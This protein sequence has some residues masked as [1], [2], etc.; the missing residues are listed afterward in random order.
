M[1]PRKSSCDGIIVLVICPFAVFSSSCVRVFLHTAKVFDDFSLQLP[2]SPALPFVLD[3]SL[4]NN[5]VFQHLESILRACTIVQIF[6]S[7][8]RICPQI[9]ENLFEIKYYRP[10]CIIRKINERDR[11]LERGTN[12][13]LFLDGVQILSSRADTF[14]TTPNQPEIKQRLSYTYHL[15]PPTHLV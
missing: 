6:R 7:S 2:R 8:Y 14:A 9:K 13:S 3:V 4:G 10:N 15:F 12:V 5:D 1:R 11:F